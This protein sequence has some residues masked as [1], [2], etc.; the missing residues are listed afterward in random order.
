MHLLLVDLTKRSS[1]LTT[2]GEEEERFVDIWC[3]E[4]NV[5]VTYIAFSMGWGIE[6][7]FVHKIYSKASFSI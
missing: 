1:Y 3:Q 6:L 2:F 5:T 7:S 4:D